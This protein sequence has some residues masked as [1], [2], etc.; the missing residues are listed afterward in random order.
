MPGTNSTLHPAE[1]IGQTLRMALHPQVVRLLDLVA[2]AGDPPVW[3]DTPQN[4]RD[5]RNSR[6]RPSSIEVPIIWDLDA[7]GTKARLY[8]PA[9]NERF[10]LTVFFHGGGWVLGSL[11]THDAAVRSLV[12]A[13]GHAVLSVD[14]RL[15]PEHPFPAGLSDALT[16]TRW[17]HQHAAE[18][19]CDPDRLAVMGDS[20]GGNLAAVVAQLA[21]V[22]LRFQVLVYPVMDMA[23]DTASYAEFEHGPLLARRAMEWFGEQYVGGTG[24]DLLDPRVSPGRASDTALRACP[25]GMVITAEVDPLRDEGE[26][27]A[28]RLTAL[29]VPTS[30]TRY[31]GMIHGFVSSLEFV[32]A[33]RGAIGEI[34]ARLR[35]AFA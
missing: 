8:R 12:Q 6:V 17:A 14:Y 33:G 1:G 15:A 34:A 22:P 4:S 35:H 3:D 21:P 18:F 7:G 31:H 19:G 2:Q 11:D 10:G 13:S 23:M 29:G 24:T 30:L 28:E 20:A 26:A 5:R 32:D 25:P 16:V 9:G 27:Y